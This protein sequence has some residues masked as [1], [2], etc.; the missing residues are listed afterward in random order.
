MSKITGKV[1][2]KQ[3]LKGDTGFTY[4]QHVTT[5]GVLYWSNNGNLPN[6]LPVNIKGKNGDMVQEEEINMIKEKIEKN[7]YH[8]SNISELKKANLKIGNVCETLGYYHIE[9]GGGATYYISDNFSGIGYQ[10]L[11]NGLYA[12]LIVGKNKKINV[13]KLGVKRNVEINQ[14]D[15]VNKILNNDPKLILYFPS[16][17][18]YFNKGIIN[19]KRHDIIGDVVTT[20]DFDKNLNG[21]RFIFNNVE[22]NTILLDC[23][24]GSRV[25]I[26]DIYI[27]SNNVQITEDRNI[28]S[29]DGS[30][31]DMFTINKIRDNIIGLKIGL[32]G[33]TVNNVS[34]QGCNIG[35]EGNTYNSL[36]NISVLECETGIVILNDNQLTNLKI[37]RN[38]IGLSIRGSLNTIVNYRCDSI[39]EYGIKTD[40]HANSNNILGY[41]GDWCQ[42][43]GAFINSDNNYISGYIGRCGTYY[44]N[45]EKG[46]ADEPEKACLFYL[47]NC[48]NNRIDIINNYESVG[49]NSNDIVKTPSYIFVLGEGG[50]NNGNNIT[51]TGNF[52]ISTEKT[53]TLEELNFIWKL[54]G[55]YGTNFINIYGTQY[56]IKSSTGIYSKENIYQTSLIN[57]K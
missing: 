45:A 49:D 43:G 46:T 8:Y 2:Y 51:I 41:V 18:Y 27:I 6:P 36:N 9:D 22:E 37:I 34:I 1:N 15:V 26:Q 48:N 40:F 19:N 38:V 4:E 56:R 57:Y 20:G 54:N 44:S 13:L 17:Y 11:N 55:S 39:K 32:F 33:N 35:L 23:Y 3:V 42:Y 53:L 5:D 16:G 24:N 30:P 10:K 25:T 29:T 31:V 21:T 12:N 7:V 28:H 50:S 47:K 14:S 52:D